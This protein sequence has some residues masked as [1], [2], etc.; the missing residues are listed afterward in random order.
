MHRR[1]VLTTATLLGVGSVAGCLGTDSGSDDVPDPVALS[2]TKY[3]YQGG[4]EIG[5]H[6][7]PN[8]QIFYRDEQPEPVAGT[9]AVRNVHQGHDETAD[10]SEEHLAWFHTLVSGLFPYHFERRNRGWEAEVIYVTDYSSVEWDL[11]ED[12]PRPVMPSPTSADSFAD[13]T[14]LTYV[15][16]SDVMGGMGPA[17]HPFSEQSE[18]ESFAETYNGTRYEFDEI[19]RGLID[20]LQNRGAM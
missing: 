10:N 12:S 11:P 13:A 17:L 7:G 18:A 2:G 6:G 19:N 14:E 4:M 1:T 15:G 8:G 9:A 5:A 3:D 16:E 20:S